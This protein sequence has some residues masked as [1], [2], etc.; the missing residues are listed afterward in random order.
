VLDGEVPAALEDVGE[1]DEIARDIGI[2]ILDGVADPCLGGEM[3]DP[4]RPKLL[5]DPHQS[6]PVGYVEPMQREAG[7]GLEVR[8]T[9]FLEGDVVIA[10]EVVHTADLIAS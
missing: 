9:R 6:I 2:G 7:M 4:V 5:K 3:D 10:V 1:P 8:G